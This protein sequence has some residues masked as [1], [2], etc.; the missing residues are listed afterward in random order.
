MKYARLAL[1]TVVGL[2]LIAASAAGIVWLTGYAKVL[3]YTVT[4]ILFIAV[5]FAVLGGAFAIAARLCINEVL[6]LRAQ[7]RE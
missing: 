4:P 7:G 1:L 3:G 2:L 6:R 5:L